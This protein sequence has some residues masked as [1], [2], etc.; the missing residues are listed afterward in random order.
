MHLPQTPNILV[1]QVIS[2]RQQINDVTPELDEMRQLVETF[3]GVVVEEIVQRLEHPDP[4]TYIGKGKLELLKQVIKDKNIHV[5]LINAIVKPGQMFRIE[6][7]LWEVSTEIAV[8]D[9]LDLILNIFDQHA[10]TTESKLQIELARIGHMG[11]RFY[12]LGGSELSRQGGGIGTRGKGE[13][14]IEFEQ[15]KV[16]LIQQKLKKQLQKT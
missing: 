8:W 9:R 1:L 4:N 11:P 6:K 7:A 10:T 14:N 16:K 15:R 2:K 3:G 13:T 5:V 12:G